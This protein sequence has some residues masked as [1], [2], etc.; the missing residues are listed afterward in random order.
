MSDNGRYLR[1]VL[2]WSDFLDQTSHAVL[3]YAILG[4]IYERIDAAV[5][6]HQDHGGAV[7]PAFEVDRASQKVEKVPE[8]G[9]RPACE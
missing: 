1:L 8:L 9:R 4:G 7:Q 6:N 2:A 3:E 5:G